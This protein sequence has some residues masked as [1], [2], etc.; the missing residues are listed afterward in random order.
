MSWINGLEMAARRQYP[1]FSLFSV[2]IGL[3]IISGVDQAGRADTSPAAPSC[4]GDYVPGVVLVSFRDGL[5]T[6]ERQA[7]LHVITT[8]PGIDVATLRAPVGQECA[9]LETL[10]QDPR[11]AFAELDYAAHATETRFFSK[12]WFL[13][14][15]DPAWPQQWGPER[16]GAPQAWAVTISTSDVIIAIVDSGVQLNHEDLAA[17]LWSNP[18]EIPDNKQDDDSNGQVD[19]FW[20]WH[21]YHDLVWNGEEY[22]YQLLEDNAVM[23]ENGHGTH[24]AGVAGARINNSVGIAGM[25]GGSR[26]M[27]VKVLD[28]YGD[29][30]YSDIAQGIIYAVDNGARVINLSLG[31]RAPSQTLQEAVNYAHAHGALMVAAAGNRDPKDGYNAV[32]YPAACEHV[33]AVAATDQDDVRSSF[34][35]HGSQVD[36]AAPGVDIYSTWYRGNYTTKDGTSMA[37]PHVSGLAALIWSTHPDRTVTRVSQIITSTAADVNSGTLLLPDWDEYLGWGRIDAGRALSVATRSGDLRL[38]A[39]SFPVAAGEMAVITASLPSTD[40]GSG[41]LNQFTFRALGGA[42]SP[43]VVTTSANTAAVTLTADS[44]PGMITVTAACLP[45]RW[46]AGGRRQAAG[47]LTGELYIRVLPGPP[48]SIALIPARWTIP[49]GSA[50]AVTLT[51]ADRFGNPPLDGT[52]VYWSAD[53][54]E[55]APSRSLYDDGASWA[56]FTAGSDYGSAVITASLETGETA[57]VTIA[58]APVSQLYL[59]LIV[60]NGGN[61]TSQ[62]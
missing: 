6:V 43:T 35:N 21:F 59:P 51:A 45:A 12:T 4:P 2:L 52:T 47:V 9:A 37:A 41:F 15:D 17:N 36:V 23:D 39:A 13:A 25:A 60:R 31:G 50:V 29:G 58:V 22:V 62:K 24:V 42:V 14:P 32:L 5:S 28:E 27:I 54:G 20:G 26:L 11:V 61:L 33:L 34:S 10:K 16:I 7:G 30:W 46:S 48:V 56:T 57:T 8:L 53:G 38:T 44:T 55:I 3:T 1:L 49:P 18:G 40:T 19:D